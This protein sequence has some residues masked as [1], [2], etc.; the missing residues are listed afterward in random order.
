MSRY[1]DITLTNPGSSTPVRHWTSHPNGKFDSGALDVEFDMP[2]AAYDTPTGAMS[3]TI[4]GIPLNDISQA[5]QFAGTEMIVKGGMQK[6]LPLANPTQ[7]GELL[8]GQVFQAFG[9]WEGTD[10]RLDLIVY[11][12]RYTN[13]NPGNIILKWNAGQ[14]LADALKNTFSVAYPGTPVI[15]NVGDNLVFSYPETSHAASL[16][17][18]AQLVSRITH[19]VFKQKVFITIQAG[20]IRVFDNT[21]KPAPIQMN[22]TD[23]VGQPTWLSQGIMQIKTVMRAD[24]QVGSIILMPSLR[25]LGKDQVFPNAPGFTT[26][27]VSSALAPDGGALPSTDKNSG[28]FKNKFQVS[29]L[30]HI[31]SYRSSAGEDWVTVFNCAQVG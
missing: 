19:E 5:H 12:S 31:G 4:Y 11:P 17:E 28:T 16:E 9:N 15:F 29:E 27:Y 18:L 21:Y 10:M 30:R 26:T 6:G 2:I 3:V 14:T 25:Y 1:Y 8:R 24:I 20:V 23:L 13:E 22:F 7:A